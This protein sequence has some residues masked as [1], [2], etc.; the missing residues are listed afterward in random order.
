MGWKYAQVIRSPNYYGWKLEEIF[1]TQTSDAGNCVTSSFALDTDGTASEIASNVLLSQTTVIVIFATR[2]YLNDFITELDKMGTAAQNLILIVSHPWSELLHPTNLDD[3]IVFDINSPSLLAFEQYLGQ[4]SE[5][6]SRIA[7]NP[8]FVEFIEEA[9]QCDIGPEIRFNVLCYDLPSRPLTTGS[10]YRQDNTVQTTINA[11]YA[12]AGALDLALKEVCGENYDAICDDFV[13]LSAASVIS[14]KLAQV[15]FTDD[16]GTSFEF[17]NGAN[18]LGFMLRRLESGAFL[19][20]SNWLLT[21]HAPK[22][23]EET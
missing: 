15:T 7:Q 2:D 18:E 12:Y 14:E 22:C 4:V 23:F 16:S 20:V 19:P 10:L 13:P 9:F 21:H 17:T 1:K 3:A 5:D 6:Q 8:W 11:V